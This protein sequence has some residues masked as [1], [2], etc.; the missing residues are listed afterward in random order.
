LVSVLDGYFTGKAASIGKE[1][2]SKAKERIGCARGW[3]SI[4]FS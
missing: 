2:E 1:D 4:A 3:R